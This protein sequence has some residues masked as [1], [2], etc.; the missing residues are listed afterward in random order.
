MAILQFQITKPALTEI[1]KGLNNS[2]SY[3]NVSI[4]N[5]AQVE[6]DGEKLFMTSTDGNMLYTVEFKPDILEQKG[7]IKEVLI[8]IDKLSKIKFCTMKKG[9][10]FIHITIDDEFGFIILDPFND[11]TYKIK[12]NEG[13]FPEWKKLIDKKY[14][15]RKQRTNIYLNRRYL[16]N[17]LKN[18]ASNFRH[19]IIELNVPKTDD[20]NKPI[21]ITGYDADTE[22]KTRTL[23]MQMQIREGQYGY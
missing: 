18:T 21:Y 1:I 22:I 12:K 16:E 3:D 11:I 7:K 5:N 13:K 23:L 6:F 14:N 20:V 17:I 15:K 4:L 19:E 9:L 8:P 10:D 2:S